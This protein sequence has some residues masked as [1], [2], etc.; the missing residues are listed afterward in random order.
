MS[1]FYDTAIS[2]DE[3]LLSTT[4]LG[5]EDILLPSGVV[6]ADVTRGRLPYSFGPSR[7]CTERRIKPST[8]IIIHAI[9]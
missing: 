6:K 9:I 5:S 3:N 4:D 8:G 2:A 7:N 1:V